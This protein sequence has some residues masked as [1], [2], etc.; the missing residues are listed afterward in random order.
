MFIKS[1]PPRQSGLTGKTS[2]QFTK[3]QATAFNISGQ[4]TRMDSK[5]IGSNIETAVACSGSRADSCRS[6]RP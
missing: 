3:T 2:A 6:V 1:E 5:L 4:Q